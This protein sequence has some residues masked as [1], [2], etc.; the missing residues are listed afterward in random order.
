MT[1]QRP[2]ADEQAALDAICAVADVEHFRWIPETH[3][4]K[5]PDLELKLA[6]GRTAF[7]EV[8]LSV[9]QAAASLKGAAGSKKPFR[10]EELAW[11]WTVWVTDRHPQERWQLGR[12]LKHF[13]EAM[14]PVLACAEAENGS[15]ER[16]QQ[17]ATAMF[18]AK[19][20]RLNGFAPGSPRHG[21]RSKPD[22]DTSF[23]ERALRDWLATC[24]YWYLPDLED[25]VLH[26]LV[27]R[28]AVV[29]AAPTPAADGC[30]SI[31]THVSALEGAFSFAAADYLVP[32]IERAVANKQKKNQMAGYEGEHW[33]AVA[34]EGNAAAQLE[35]ACALQPSGTAP[36][37]SGV[38]FAGFD[39][40]WVIGCTFH[41]WRFA[42][43]R[44][45]D[46]GQQPVLCIVPRPP[47]AEAAE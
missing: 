26:K 36:D 40:L 21:R 1:S 23:E 42:V 17:D 38:R 10:F 27:P 13:V 35:E 28:R 20:F 15:P 33:L 2:R 16:M 41:D 46:A 39:E 44:F 22:V 19:P 11:D 4:Q 7:V 18:D 6:D 3:Q 5:T 14:V 9:D 31:E 37:L 8:T 30:G 47:K 12:R 34:V 24:G 25:S 43:A 29:A 45:A 32:A